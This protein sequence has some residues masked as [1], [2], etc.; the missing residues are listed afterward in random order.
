MIGGVS[1][2]VY[3][4]RPYA[5][6]PVPPVEA[7]TEAPAVGAGRRAHDVYESSVGREPPPAVTY[8]PKRSCY[9]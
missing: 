6:E 8:G 9:G 5:P 4:S 3:L 1:P 7:A 2:G